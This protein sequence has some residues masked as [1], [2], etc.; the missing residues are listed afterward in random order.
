VRSSFLDYN[1]ESRS[2][3]ALALDIGT[4]GM[5]GTLGVTVVTRRAKSS[6][7]PPSEYAV[8]FGGN[9]L[10]RRMRESSS[11]SGPTT[12]EFAF[13]LALDRPEPFGVQRIFRPIFL[14]REVLGSHGM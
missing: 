11:F 14:G 1:F 9:N 3:V 5:L 6:S 12:L 7:P 2:W 4:L 13:G 10:R 8:P